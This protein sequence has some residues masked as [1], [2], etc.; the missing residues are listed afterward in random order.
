MGDVIFWYSVNAVAGLGLGLIPLFVARNKGAMKYGVSA[1]ALCGVG[2][3]LVGLLASGLVALVLTGI[4]VWSP[5]ERL[6]ALGEKEA[7]GGRDA[8]IVI[9]FF[10]VVIGI[11]VA[12][13]FRVGALG[14]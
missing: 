5:P 2:G 13:A 10:L 1:L 4:A 11:L 3:L 12:W 7:A 9:A 14:G 6:K 8:G